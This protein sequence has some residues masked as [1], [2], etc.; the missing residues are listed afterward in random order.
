MGLVAL[1]AAAKVPPPAQVAVYAVIA[2][3]PLLTGAVKTMVAEVLPAV[4]A[5]MVGAPGAV[6]GTN[7]VTL[8]A[9]DAMLVP[10]ALVAVT[11]QM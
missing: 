9:L 3:P 8:T 2:E 6:A 7:G 10:T 11:V 5:P 1:V 4:A